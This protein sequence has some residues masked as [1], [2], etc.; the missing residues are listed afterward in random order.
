MRTRPRACLSE[1]FTLSNSASA[2]SLTS[3]RHNR[4]PSARH[5]A[6]KLNAKV[7]PNLYYHFS[8]GT[9]NDPL[10]YRGFALIRKKPE[11]FTKTGSQTVRCVRANTCNPFLQC[12]SFKLVL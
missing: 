6:G 7:N 9:V 4:A 5:G 11:A 1:I 2:R 10:L 3:K 8:C 12:T